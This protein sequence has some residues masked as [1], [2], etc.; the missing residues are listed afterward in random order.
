[1]L[2]NFNFRFNFFIF[3][4]IKYFLIKKVPGLGMKCLAHW[5]RE[6]IKCLFPSIEIKGQKGR[7]MPTAKILSVRPNNT[8]QGECILNHTHW[9]WLVHIDQLFTK[10]QES[11]L[12]GHRSERY[13]V[14]LEM[15]KNACGTKNA[16]GNFSVNVLG[17][18]CFRECF[19]SP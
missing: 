12:G 6:H 13:N 17:K 14:R 19:S 9:E 16:Y 10:N 5:G 8:G 7:G 15:K 2:I 11:S 4:K 3:F 1:M 18:L